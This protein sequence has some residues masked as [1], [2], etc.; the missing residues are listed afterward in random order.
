MPANEKSEDRRYRARS[1]QDMQSEHHSKRDKYF[2]VPRTQSRPNYASR[3]GHGIKQRISHL[4][5]CWALSPGRPG[6][7]VAPRQP[8][9]SRHAACA[10]RLVPP[11]TVPTSTDGM[12]TDTCPS[13]GSMISV[14]NLS[15]PR[16]HEASQIGCKRI[17]SEVLALAVRLT[18]RSPFSISSMSVTHVLDSTF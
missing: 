3:L 16:R 14:E 8:T 17:N 10:G 11:P 2:P 18:M 6:D 7:F 13:M 1:K 4:A 9:T 12:V 5:I 15:E